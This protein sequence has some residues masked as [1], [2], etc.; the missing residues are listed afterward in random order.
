MGETKIE[1]LFE[2]ETAVPVDG[3]AFAAVVPLNHWY[4]RLLPVAPTVS[5][6]EVPELTDEPTGC[7]VIAGFW[8]VTLTTAAVLSTVVG[9]HCPVTRTKYVVVVEGLTLTEEDVAPGIGLL[10]LPG[11]PMYH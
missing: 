9:A 5:C 11:F 6:A 8:Q 7:W 1:G 2:L 4:V 10:V 3:V